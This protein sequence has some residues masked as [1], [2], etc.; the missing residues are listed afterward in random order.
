MVTV[1]L[2][3][4]WLQLSP[5]HT[6]SLAPINP[7]WRHSGAGWP[8][9]TWKMAIKLEREYELEIWQHLST[10]LWADVWRQRNV[11]LA[12]Q[13]LACLLSRVE[14]LAHWRLHVIWALQ[15]WDPWPR[16]MYQC[17]WRWPAFTTN[18]SFTDKYYY[19][20]VS[21]IIVTVLRYCRNIDKSEWEITCALRSEEFQDNWTLVSVSYYTA[22]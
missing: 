18:N 5:P 19:N 12:T 1:W 8:R 16:Q 6:S 13:L 17:S 11:L 4:L 21:A 10:G 15:C 20:T 9:S 14:L 3:I 2:L 22:R 7:E